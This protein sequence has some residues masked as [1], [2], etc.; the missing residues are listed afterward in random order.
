MNEIVILDGRVFRGFSDSIA[1]NQDEYLLDHLRSARNADASRGHD[2]AKRTKEERAEDLLTRLF[3]SGRTQHVL[4][5]ILTEEGRA[6]NR[7]D[8]DANALRFA[9]ITDVEEKIA[10]RT[11]LANFVVGF[12]S[13]DERS[14]AAWVN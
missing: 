2:G 12:C 4:A 7:T 10:M 6:W 5:G 3:L 9:E 14:S 13:V 8:A 11:I 1:E